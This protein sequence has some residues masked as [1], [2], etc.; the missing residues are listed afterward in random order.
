M[1]IRP[2]LSLS[3]VLN[4]QRENR[5]VN[6]VFEHAAV[7]VLAVR[8]KR[9]VSGRNSWGR[10]YLCFARGWNGVLV[11]RITQCQVDDIRK[12]FIPCNLVLGL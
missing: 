9:L 7:R 11:V 3:L 1:E 4:L 10:G 6:G 8:V 12:W 2:G 5:I